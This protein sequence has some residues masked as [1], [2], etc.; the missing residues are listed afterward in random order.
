MKFIDACEKKTM[1]F[2]A[3]DLCEGFVHKGTPFLKISTTTAFNL[4][5]KEVEDIFKS[6]YV[7]PKIT[8]I[9]FK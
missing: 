5:T 4:L 6:E 8:T 9:T 2:F 1:P 3:L 7:E